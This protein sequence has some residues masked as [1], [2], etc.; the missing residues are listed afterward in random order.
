[1][2]AVSSPG[3]TG[4]GT[5]M[6]QPRGHGAAVLLDDMF[7]EEIFSLRLGD[8]SA[9]SMAAGLNLKTATSQIV[10]G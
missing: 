6:L 4:F 8:F 5:R 1:M 2:I 10:G 9:S 7:A 3:S